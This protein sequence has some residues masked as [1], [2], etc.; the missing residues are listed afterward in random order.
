MGNILQSDTSSKRMH[1]VSKVLTHGKCGKKDIVYNPATVYC[2]KYSCSAV[3]DKT[4]RRCTNLAMGR[5]GLG[6]LSMLVLELDFSSACCKL[7][8]E[9]FSQM[10]RRLQKIS[11]AASR[12]IILYYL[13]KDITKVFGNDKLLFTVTDGPRAGR[14]QQIF[15]KQ[16]KSPYKVL[17][18]HLPMFA[19]N[20]AKLFE[21]SVNNIYGNGH[22][23]WLTKWLPDYA[24]LL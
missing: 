16:Q 6:R 24:Q 9:H 21:Q 1:C 3:C 12:Q 4:G 17:M 2:K 14:S 15:G 8:V 22:G 11:H 20:L 19:Y 13:S 23:N 5:E 18:R 7:C 10:K